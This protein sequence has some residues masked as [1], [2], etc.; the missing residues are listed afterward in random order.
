MELFANISIKIKLL[1]LALLPLLG[2][3]YFAISGIQEK[4]Q[5][6]I[7]MGGIEVLSS[8]AVNASALVHETQKERGATAGFL[9]SKG[10][11]F[12]S[13]LSG[14]RSD[15]DAKAAKLR[16]FLKGFDADVYGN[17]F[18]R[19]MNN[20]IRQLDGISS[21]RSS[22]SSQTISAKSAIGYYTQMNSAFLD[23]IAIGAKITDQ[24]KVVREITAYINFLLGKERAGIERAVL[25]NVF[26]R[27]SFSE[28]MF[29]R[30]ASLVTQQD[31]YINVF[32][33]L[34]SEEQKSFYKNKMSGDAV[35]TVTRMREV[36][37]KKAAQG[38]F[39]IKGSDW[40]RAATGR[41]NL[42]RQIEDRL[43][44]DLKMLAEN[45]KIDAESQFMLYITL[46]IIIVILVVLATVTFTRSITRP[47]GLAVDVVNQMAEGNL[48]AKIDS[49]SRDEVGMML[50]SLRNTLEKL[51]QTISQVRASAMA[52]SSASEE[53]SAT[54]QSMNQGASEQA[55][56][57]EETSASIE[58]MTASITQNTENAKVTN[59]MALQA[60]SHAAESGE[61]VRQTVEAMGEIAKKI[62]IIDDIAYQTNL[63]ALNAAIE[64]ARAGEHGKGF[65]VVASEV[66]KLAERSQVAAEEISEK[67]RTSVDVA[68][69]AGN[70]LIEMVPVIQKT[71]SLVQEIAAASEEQSASVGQ[72]NNAMEELNKI[73]QTNASASEEL[74]ATSEEMSGQ[75]QNLQEMMAYFK[76]DAANE[77]V[78]PRVEQ[79]EAQPQAKQP[80]AH[81]PSHA[82]AS[83]AGLVPDA[84]QFV[85]F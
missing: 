82:G 9:G 2:L 35:Q 84:N 57:V 55:A 41:I 66:R 80:M 45:L 62:T 74:A 14:Q 67:A 17:E 75:S 22:V 73:T 6:A 26:A 54:A 69:K 78:A 16:D 49:S 48:E 40:F 20:A 25:S 43:S 42:L 53:V 59:D 58:Q 47:L 85:K 37:F 7:E 70:L 81:L 60:A 12:V 65:A 83:D 64:A 44:G 63:L 4:R 50:G 5:V 28:G 33:A 1:F 76:V 27:G 71:S 34:A 10:T 68:E 15:T 51:S 61:A 72:V 24:G 39:G 19:T 13:E 3:L 56:S 18:V 21:I 77:S 36:A 38:N 30:F 23:A 31:T 29:Q 32:T 11:S 8:F 46:T 79:R 52:M